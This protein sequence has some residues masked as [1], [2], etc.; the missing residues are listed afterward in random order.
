MG[1][2][3]L[4][5]GRRLQHGP[6]GLLALPCGVS[7]AQLDP[8][9]AVDPAWSSRLAWTNLTKLAPWE[10][11]NP[12]G[13]LLDVQRRTGP[14]LLAIEVDTWKPEVVLVLTG[15]WWVEPFVRSLGLDVDWRDGL[16]ERVPS[17]GERPW[18]TAPHPQGKPRALWDEVLAAL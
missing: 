7:F 18:V 15:R 16:A 8:G 17:D 14:G 2:R 10:G 12:G 3:S 13:G 1:H 5:H 4:G 9:S 11:G 6:V